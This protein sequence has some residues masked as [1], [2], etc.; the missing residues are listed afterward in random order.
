MRV[1]AGCLVGVCCALS[2]WQIPVWQSNTALWGQAMAVSPQQPRPSLNYGMAVIGT[3]Q[4][5]GVRFLVRAARQAYGHPREREVAAIVRHRL[6][7]IEAFGGD[8]CSRPFVSP[9]C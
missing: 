5:E 3:N 2:A 1:I 8:V 6:W 9:H 4:D 7:W